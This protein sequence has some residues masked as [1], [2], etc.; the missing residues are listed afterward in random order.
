[1]KVLTQ[2]LKNGKIHS[3]INSTKLEKINIFKYMLNQIVN[4][5][6]RLIRQPARVKGN[7]QNDQLELLIHLKQLKIN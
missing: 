7:K 4:F 2:K 1:M 3:S 5:G 6:K